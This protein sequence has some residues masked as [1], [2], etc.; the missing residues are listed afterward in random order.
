MRLGQLIAT[1]TDEQT[2]ELAHKVI[3]GAREVDPALWPHNIEL[4]LRQ[5]GHVEQT[6]V[7]RRPPVLAVLLQLLSTDGFAAKKETFHAEAMK[8]THRWCDRVSSGQL[9]NR[10]PKLFRIYRRLLTA[11][12][13][14]DL[15]L[16]ASE[17]EL[18]GLLRKEIGMLQVEHFLISHHPDIQPFWRDPNAFDFVIKALVDTG[19]LFEFDGTVYLPLELVPHVRKALGVDMRRAAARRLYAMLDSG[20][21]LK[22]ALGDHDLQTSGSKETR[23]ERLVENFIPPMAVIDTVHISDLRDLG[24]KLGVQVSGAKEELVKRIIAHFETGQD[25]LPREDEVEAEIPREPRV[26]SD[27]QFTALFSKLK[28]RQL[29]AV[30]MKFDLKHSGSKE[31][32]VGT[33]RESHLNAESILKKLTNPE[34]SDLLRK[35]SL[36][37]KGSKETRIQRILDFHGALTIGAVEDKHDFENGNSKTPSDGGD[38]KAPGE[39]GSSETAV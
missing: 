9:A 34:L 32:R 18:L 38:P 35:D 24:R 14:N 12:W 13:Q 16:D 3:P 7:A 17:T 36:E 33:L 30:L 21:H 5:S 27:P 31:L 15:V 25:L 29:Q 22:V 23:I 11:A 4:I 37:T 8:T 26:L 6:I 1:L 19:V 20:N 39:T 28:G 2:K 10:D